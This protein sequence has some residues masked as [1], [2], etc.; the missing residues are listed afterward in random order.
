MWGNRIWLVISWRYYKR[1]KSLPATFKYQS[2][3]AS[4][5]VATRSIQLE[6][7]DQ[8]EGNWK[9]SQPILEYDLELPT[10]WIYDHFTWHGSVTFFSCLSQGISALQLL[11]R[12]VLSY[13]TCQ[14]VGS[15]ESEMWC[16]FLWLFWCVASNCLCI[17][18][19]SRHDVYYV[20]L[21]HW[22]KL[23]VLLGPPK[24]PLDAARKIRSQKRRQ[25]S[26]LRQ[27]KVNK[28]LHVRGIHFQRK[29]GRFAS[30]LL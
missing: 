26:Q 7:L 27:R 4:A 3:T 11:R 22:H 18:D 30:T 17:S 14:F 9:I 6:T 13:C 28:K 21:Q 16:H 1:V 19:R 15:P 29:T 2:S 24:S 10:L 8:V 12:A 25:Q 5:L 20:L 23:Q